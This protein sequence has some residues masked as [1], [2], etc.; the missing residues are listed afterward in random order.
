MPKA[1]VFIKMLLSIDFLAFSLCFFNQV[2]LVL[3]FLFNIKDTL[4]LLS[5]GQ[6]W[7]NLIS[8]LVLKPIEKTNS[9][10]DVVE[11]YNKCGVDFSEKEYQGAEVVNQ[12]DRATV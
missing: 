5:I 10:L 2:C 11:K 6:V 9:T 1:R 7:G 4:H 3:F 8:Y 12:I